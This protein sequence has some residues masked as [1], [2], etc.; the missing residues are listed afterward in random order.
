[1]AVQKN[2]MEAK[3][4]QTET[5]MPKILSE[6]SAHGV[7]SDL[8]KETKNN[9][10]LPRSY[11]ELRIEKE[12]QDFS[13]SCSG[14]F[15]KTYDGLIQAINYLPYIPES[16]LYVVV[17]NLP[18][19]A[20]AVLSPFMIAGKASLSFLGFREE[21]NFSKIL[22]EEKNDIL[23]IE[24]KSKWINN[25]REVFNK[26]SWCGSLLG[27]DKKFANTTDLELKEILNPLNNISKSFVEPLTTPLHDIAHATVN[28]LTHI[29]YN[30]YLNYS[31][32]R[33]ISYN[34]F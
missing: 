26:Y 12:V 15:K 3:V 1:M 14:F 20:R 32:K 13:K 30:I 25:T 27:D 11:S 18:T 2:K 7:S 28:R 23:M 19:I 22:T 6:S 17:Y 16:I 4:L 21:F 5:A 8:N 34:D 9:L 10:I 33:T 31:E 29:S 24:A